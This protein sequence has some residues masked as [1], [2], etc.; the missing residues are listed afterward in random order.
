MAKRHYPRI[1]GF[2]RMALAGVM[3]ASAGW[4]VS[5]QIV[6]TWS[7]GD[8]IS[9]I[10]APSS[11][12]LLP[13]ADTLNISGA[14]NH[15][16]DGLSVTNNGTVN[17]TAGNLRSG[18]GGIFTN[19]AT[20][21][22]TAGTGDF[23]NDYGGAGGTTFLNAATGTYLKSAG[24]TTFSIGF[25]NAGTLSVTGGTLSL[26][27]GGTFSA[28]SIAGSS[29]AGVLQL[30][31]GTLMASGSMQV[32]NLVL[33]GGTLA[34]DHTF[35]NSVLSWQAGSMNSANTTTLASNTTMN[36]QGGA[37]HDFQAHTIVNDG[38]V[39]WTAGNVRSGSGGTIT[40]NGTWQDASDGYTLN[41]DY[42]GTGGT[43]FINAAGGTYLKTA[44]T[45]TLTVGLTNFGTV[46]ATGGVLNLAAG[47]TF[48][49]GSIIGSSGS[50]VVQLT[51]GTLTGSG[52]TGFDASNFL[53]TGGEVAGNITFLGATAWTGSNFNNA[54]GT[55][56]VGV[57]GVLNIQGAGNHDF[58]GHA[59]VNNGTVNWTAGQVRSGSGGTFTN[60][61]T[62]NDSANGYTINNDY[63]GTGGTTFINAAGGTYL[64][65]AGTTTFADN[66]LVNHGTISVTGGT[67]NL[68]GG[69]LGDGS[70]IGSSGAGVVQLTSGTLTANGDINVQNF[71]LNGGVLAGTHTFAGALDWQAGTLNNAGST[72]IGSGSTLTVGSA[73][74]HDFQSHTIF[75]NGTV[76]WQAGHLRSGSGGT[77][78]NNG[79]WNDSAD[80]YTVNND[81]G[82]TGGT[83]F[84]NAS[85]GIYSK[86][87]GVT[88]FADSTLVN[89]GI[90]SVSGGTLNLNGGA[91]N[92]GSS[93]GSSGA[94][95]VQLTSGTLT[96]NG[97][98][99]VQNF[100]LNGGVLA[101]VQTFA[102]TLGWQ[103]GT[104]NNTGTTT[105][106]NG[107]T[108][109][110]SGAA[111]H[112][113]QSHT[114]VNDGTVNWQAGHLRSGSGGT[115]TNNG[116]WNDSASGYTVNNDYGGSGGTSFVNAAG[117][118]YA[119]SA[120]TTTFTVPLTNAGTLTLAGGTLALQSTF[121]NTGTVT[122]AAGAALTSSSP[123]TFAVGSK[124]QGG[125][126]VTASALSLSGQLDPGFGTTT[127]QLSLTTNLTLAGTAQ[128]IFD[129][130]GATAAQYDSVLVSGTL[131]LGGTLAVRFVD[132]FNLT[133]DNAMTFTLAT[134]TTLANAFT[135][136]AN[137]AQLVT[138]DGLGV[139]T[140]NYGAASPF[141]VNTLVLSNFN[142]IPEPSTWALMLSGA[143]ML[144][145][146]ARRRR[147]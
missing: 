54:I 108:L 10:I 16:F 1:S 58:Q 130:G 141:G 118:T 81:Y 37:N 110:I 109:T 36:I 123:L 116:T 128:S 104:L 39:N 55:A 21:N 20:W 95:I 87:A 11:I 57:T 24:T 146:M 137:G 60:N 9:G 18:H 42:G 19:N 132:N 100:L 51:G 66:T 99:N 129:L 102:G 53:L 64:K 56:T 31:G 63:G 62:W 122:V 140:V 91:L 35:T 112:D 86:T 106:G 74:N 105:M 14:T 98:I 46:S 114:I 4:S 93:I 77:I 135:N 68:N 50:G 33:A 71:L 117:G 107:S 119:K 139:F 90:I 3:W 30:T 126:T 6:Y 80:G 124:L 15:D 73:A 120:G 136:V 8:L 43:S 134:G 147:T 59:M 28:G 47:G 38:T 115:I 41:N 125:G 70:S 32:T 44:G 34:G 83:T 40:N 27:N 76:N 85:G 143:G 26:A 79:A 127:G 67:L 29:G 133:A 88:T 84:I 5:A 23:N 144:G 69:A 13:A 72:T 49:D 48:H 111:N 2:V 82:G 78:T 89:H 65:T 142:A 12:T 92:N 94:G 22:D 75:N 25:T 103:N 131:T 138:T 52:T 121:A 145:W 101:G 45:T 7:S 17:W 96:A 113:F 61:G 97:T